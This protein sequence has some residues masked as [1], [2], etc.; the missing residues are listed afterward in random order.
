MQ[1]SSSDNN[2]LSNKLRDYFENNIKLWLKSKDKVF[3]INKSD[4]FYE[5][6]I[7]YEN[8]SKFT[9]SNDNSIIDK[10]IVKELCNKNIIDLSYGESHYIART[11]DNKIYCWG[12]NY[13]RQLGNG[14]EDKNKLNKNIPELNALLSDL[15]IS[16]IKCGANH[17]LALTQSGEVYAWGWNHCGQIGLGDNNKYFKPTKVNVLNENKIKMISCGG[18]HSLALTESGCVYVWGDNEFGQL[19]IENIKS[20]NTPKILELK[21]IRIDK[22]SCGAN[23]SLLLTNDRVIYAFG[24]NY[25]G[26]I[27]NGMRAQIQ[28]KLQKL[29]HE[30]R[31]IDMASHWNADISIAL[32][33]DNIYY[34]WGDCKEECNLK[35]I[36]TKMRSFNEILVHF[37][38]YSYEVNDKFIEFSDLFLEDGY[39][40]R[41]FNEIETISAGSYG[42]VFKVSNKGCAHMWAVKKISLRKEYKN[43]I[44]RE[45][46]NFSVVYKLS[47][48]YVVEHYY[49]WL[50][51]SKTDNTITLF[52]GMEL[53]DK[54]L[55]QLIDEINRDSNMKTN[56][57]L[58]LMAYYIS[59]QLFI[60]I[61]ECVQY[62]HENQIIHRDINPLNIMIKMNEQNNRFIKMCD[63]GL[64]AIHSFAQQSHTRDRGRVRYAAPEVLN[65]RKYDTK[66]DIYSLGILLL[67]L[68]DFDVRYC[69]KK[70]TK[71]YFNFFFHL[72]F[73]SYEENNNSNTAQLLIEPLLVL[74][75]KNAIQMWESM[76]QPNPSKRPNCDQILDS[77]HL[78][79]LDKNEFQINDEMKHI[80]E[81]KSKDKQ[82][83]YH[84]IYTKLYSNY[85]QN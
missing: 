49:S 68:F 18:C 40:E 66:A 13:Y 10:M 69:H 28:I 3:T 37:C 27:A 73:S 2:I 84:I 11:I 38:G 44:I 9:E 52:I 7:Y 61:L 53:C 82:S 85:S 65:G 36:E 6:D 31:F 26:Q 39:Y 41:D 35:P 51:K 17:S 62:L 80:L 1:N 25:F 76:T 32:S 54:T 58:T 70:E 14:N 81:E 55:Q 5:I 78:W 75:Y 45:M 12:N 50:E 34:V 30:K 83:V 59:S 71:N 20:L 57:I 8:I 42:T 24:S 79:A 77:Q 67:N 60:E 63:F 33:L 23:H 46:N 43:E 22:I 29:N 21:D 15:N 16:V 4:V 64:I 74:K 19:G 56:K 47:N 48:R 72:N